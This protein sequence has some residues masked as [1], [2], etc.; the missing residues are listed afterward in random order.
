MPEPQGYLISEADARVLADVLA[1]W[2]GRRV[3]PRRDRD[4]EDVPPA[5]EVYI[6]KTPLQGIPRRR[7]TPG[8]S[9]GTGF[10]Y[11][12]EPGSALCQVQQ[13][14]DLRLPDTAPGTWYSQ[15]G[16]LRGIENFYIRVYNLEL[17]DLDP[18]IYI[19]AVRDKFG[20]W[21]AMT[22]GT[23]CETSAAYIPWTWYLDCT[24]S[25]PVI[26]VASQKRIVGCFTIEDVTGTGT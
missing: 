16:E 6:V 13:L 14:I 3:N 25:P 24:V 23:A 7:Q 17:V 8:P 1:W 4:E 12:D 2:R 10:G 21:W 22:G 26:R 15:T 20:K 9:T 11:F 5:P 18:G 19:R